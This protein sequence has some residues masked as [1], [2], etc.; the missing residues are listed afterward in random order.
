MQ[1]R[2][3][4]GCLRYF[5]KLRW[6]RGASTHITGASANQCCSATAVL[7][8]A[9]S[10]NPAGSGNGSSALSAPWGNY[11]DI[12]N[13]G[14]EITLT[15]RPFIGNFSWE[16]SIQFSV[17]RNKLVNLS[18]GSTTAVITGIGQW[19]ISR[20]QQH[21]RPEDPFTRP[22]HKDETLNEQK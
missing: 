18:D 14:V 19:I 13:R 4:F 22:T 10:S 9:A 7:A 16:S 2:Y 11:G 1:T 6:K 12:R 3:A 15:G 5:Q 17:N 20:N 8:N 21:E